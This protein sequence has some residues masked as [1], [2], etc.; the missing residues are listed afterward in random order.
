M[1]VRVCLCAC[2]FCASV[3]C[4]VVVL[5]CWCDDV[6]LCVRWRCDVVLVCC[7]AGMLLCCRGVVVSSVRVFVCLCVSVLCWR[8]IAVSVLLCCCGVLLN[9]CGDV[10]L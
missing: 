9:C 5:S 10:L 7:S 3:L 4:C 2:E 8:V 1:C 6:L